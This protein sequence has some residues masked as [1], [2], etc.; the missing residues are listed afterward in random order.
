MQNGEENQRVNYLL[1]QKQFQKFYEFLTPRTNIEF[2]KKIQEKDL[3]YSQKLFPI[4]DFELETIKTHL[5]NSL[6]EKTAEEFPTTATEV[7]EKDKELAINRLNETPPSPL[8]QS[9]PSPSS[10]LISPAICVWTPTIWT[11]FKTTGSPK[12]LK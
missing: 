7:E 1:N 2:I 12:T 4:T 10:S 9:S 6:K 8:S 11:S 3:I 5:K